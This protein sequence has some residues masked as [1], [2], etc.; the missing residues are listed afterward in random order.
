MNKIITTRLATLASAIALLGSL[1]FSAQAQQQGYAP[2]PAQVAPVQAPPAMPAQRPAY[3]Y[4][5]RGNAPAPYQGNT[6]APYRG[7]APAPYYGNR[8]NRTPWSG[9]NMPWSGNRSGNMPWG[10]NNMPWSGNRS[11]NMPWGGNRSGSMPWG[12]NRTPWGGNRSRKGFGRGM[13]FES[14]FTPWSERFWD[15]LGDGGRNPFK[16]M[17]EWVDP[18]DPRE[19]MG[20]MW[21]D[22][23]NAPSDMGRMPGGWTA[24]SVSVPNPVDVQEEFEDA[25]KDMPDEMRT[26]MDNINIQT[27]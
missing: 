9:N 5:Y 12:G 20:D 24:P 7:N 19:G 15:D 27:W 4:P 3:G 8:S 21:D 16:D 14:N 10:G 2:Y 18:N 6:P 1:S 25:A 11:G 23:L 17:D 22:L 13:P 26:Q